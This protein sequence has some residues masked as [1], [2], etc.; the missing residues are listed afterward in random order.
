MGWCGVEASMLPH[1]RAKDQA[2]R[3]CSC[4]EEEQARYLARLFLL[5][6]TVPWVKKVYFFQVGQS[7]SYT[8][9]RHHPDAYIGIITPEGA[10]LTRPKEAY[11]SVKT[12][13]RMLRGATV[14]RRID[15]GRRTWGLVLTRGK[16]VTIALWSVDDGVSMRIKD[17]SAI[18]GITSMV[19]TPM[20]LEDGALPISGRPVYVHV[21]PA[22]A[23][24]LVE[25]IHSAELTGAK[26]YSLSLGLDTDR[27][28]TD[29]PVIVLEVTNNRN[30]ARS[31]PAVQFEASVQGRRVAKL[32]TDVKPLGPGETRVR[33]ISC[34][35][36]DKGGEIALNV[37]CRLAG[38]EDEPW[39]R[40]EIRYAPI[41]RL[42]SPI[43]VD[44]SLDDW[45]TAPIIL[46]DEPEEGKTVVGWRGAD[47]CS[48]RWRLAWD[49]K[50]LY[51]A[52]TVTDDVHNQLYKRHAVNEI[53]RCDSI[54]IGL[55]MGADAKPSSNVPN[56]DGLNDVEI[57]FALTSEGPAACAW[58]NPNG[59]AGLM[60]LERLA[61]VRDEAAK[62]TRYEAAIPWSAIGYETRP[63]NRWMGLNILFNEDDG[64]HRRGALQWS[65]GM[66]F[67]KQPN[68]FNKV[69]FEN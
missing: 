46:G 56:Y 49:D 1:L 10:G 8:D 60:K 3:A 5:S 37:A 38:D 65:T 25:Q 30:S 12:V 39:L 15:L 2:H 24:A 62:S 67:R 48:A 21:D 6:A 58:V 29:S 59:K 32:V 14:T 50:A 61:I 68:L 11:Y 55:D 43:Q 16:E 36:A 42:R 19:G 47:D 64:N 63:K 20:I 22:K 9:P 4:T 34:G 41:F 17:P 45:K 7:S 28:R 27:S 35:A 40:R 66:M 23:Q 54:Q 31:F 51:F 57:G 18:K 33:P 13:I 44:G 69:V 26:E 52:A 53:W